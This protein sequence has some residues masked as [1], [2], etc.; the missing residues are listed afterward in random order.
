[1]VWVVTANLSLVPSP[2]RRRIP[3]RRSARPASFP[4][5]P[6]PNL[7]PLARVGGSA[8]RA[9][10]R[11]FHRPLRPD[12]PRRRCTAAL[13]PR[14]RPPC[15]PLSAVLLFPQIFYMK[16]NGDIASFFRK[17]EAKAKKTAISIDIVDEAQFDEQEPTLAQIKVIH[18]I[19][20]S[21][22]YMHEVGTSDEK[23]LEPPLV[24]SKGY[25]F[26]QG[27]TCFQF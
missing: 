14:P 16:R 21:R 19:S 17:Y 25:R 13:L 18:M 6:A 26:V 2:A 11:P 9:S 7:Y 24:S 15:D 23:F 22:K 12:D 3:L 1:M 4:L 10:A 8:R 5:W 20:Q 27:Q